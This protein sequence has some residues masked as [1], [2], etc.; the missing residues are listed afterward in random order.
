[1]GWACRKM[2][3]R[4]IIILFFNSVTQRAPRKTAEN[5]ERLIF[6]TIENCNN[7]HIFEYS[8]AH[9]HTT[10][11]INFL[12]WSCDP[13]RVMAFSFLR[14]LDHTQQR[15]AVSRTPLNEWSARRRELYLTT[16]NIHNRQTDMPSVGFEPTISAGERPQAYALDR[17]ATGTGNSIYIYIYIYIY[18]CTRIYIHMYVSK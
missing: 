10:I 17:A 5:I 12:L 2:N 9:T 14:F 15:T 7:R 8:H 16:H 4:R 6:N 13:T 11:Y 18:I 3:D 1:M